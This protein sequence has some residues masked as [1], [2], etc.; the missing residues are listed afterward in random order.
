MNLS[1]EQPSRKLEYKRNP[2][3]SY[4]SIFRWR[5]KKKSNLPVVQSTPNFETPVLPRHKVNKK[6]KSTPELIEN[7]DDLAEEIIEEFR[8]GFKT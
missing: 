4:Y 2:R 8:L 5:K 7:D 3:R 1:S 6:L